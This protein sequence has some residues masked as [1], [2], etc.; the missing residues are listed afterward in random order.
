MRIQEKHH[1]VGPT[2]TPCHASSRFGRYKKEDEKRILKTDVVRNEALEKIA[3]V[4]RASDFKPEGN[5]RDE[6]LSFYKEV[7]SA[8]RT[9][10]YSPDDVSMFSLMILEFSRERFFE[11]KAGIFLSALVNCGKG[12]EYVIHT[13]HLDGIGMLGYKNRKKI[14]IEGDAHM[15]GCE[16]NGGAI[17]LHGDCINAV[18]FS[19]CSNS[20]QMMRGGTITVHG[21]WQGYLKELMGGTVIIKGDYLGD[22]MGDGMKGGT[23]IVEGD[24]RGLIGSGMEGGKIYLNGTHSR[25]SQNVFGGGIFHKGKLIAGDTFVY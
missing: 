1:G 4:W 20:A 25:I 21:D 24:A 5:R 13:A 22:E 2:L 23:I 6:A 18:S 3:E 14:T 16:M 9:M 17:T 11:D 8:V 10:G 7:S 12:D 19:G 15:I